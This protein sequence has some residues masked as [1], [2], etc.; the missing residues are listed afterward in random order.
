MRWIFLI[1]AWLSLVSVASAGSF[2]Q[3]QLGSNSVASNQLTTF[4]GVP[5]TDFGG[6][7]LTTGP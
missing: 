3:V 2:S 6:V 4:A 5:L 1:A 7:N